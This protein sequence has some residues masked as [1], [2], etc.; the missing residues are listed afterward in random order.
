[1]GKLLASYVQK[2]PAN[3]KRRPFFW[4]KKEH[5]NDDDINISELLLHCAQDN[6]RLDELKECLRTRE[7]SF[8]A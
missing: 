8:R 7:A 2:L 3:V 1:M 5:K 4:I 6:A